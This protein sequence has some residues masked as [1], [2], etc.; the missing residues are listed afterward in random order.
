M[1]TG[2]IAAGRS[3]AA[4]PVDAYP[5]EVLADSPVWYCR[6]AEPALS[7]VAVNEVGADGTYVNALLGGPALYPDGLSSWIGRTDLADHCDIPA[8]I[9]PSGVTSFT[10]EILCS[11][12]SL[13]GLQ[14]LIDRDPESGSRLWQWRLAS[15]IFNFIKVVGGIVSVN[16]TSVAGPV[17][18]PALHAVRYDATTGILTHFKNGAAVGSGSVGIGVNFGHDTVGMRINRRMQGDQQSNADSAES[19]IYL[20]A[21]SD[22]RLLAHAVAAGLA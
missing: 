3:D 6:H 13:T 5:A 16:S 8:S 21:L 19:A 1:I 2:I 9:F 7:T 12:N 14:A 11:F 22:A 18:V 10:L 4:A 20:S 17:D 15:P